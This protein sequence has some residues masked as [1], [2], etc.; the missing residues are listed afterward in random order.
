MPNK[1][2]EWRVLRMKTGESSPAQ[3]IVGRRRSCRD[4]RVGFKVDLRLLHDSYE[5]NTTYLPLKLQKKFRCDVT[6]HLEALQASKQE[7]VM[8]VFMVFDLERNALVPMPFP[9]C[10]PLDQPVTTL[11]ETKYQ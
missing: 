5:M 2:I 7:F 9:A 8:P 4:A 10:Y 1:F 11:Q 6:A 3:G